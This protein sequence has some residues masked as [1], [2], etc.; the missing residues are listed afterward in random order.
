M[1]YIQPMWYLGSKKEQI[2]KKNS[3]NPYKEG[4]M[5]SNQ[6]KSRMFKAKIL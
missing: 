5:A 1:Y 4:I 6:A 2:F 3:K